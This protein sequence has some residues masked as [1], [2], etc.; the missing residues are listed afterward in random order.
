MRLKMCEKQNCKLNKE[1]MMIMYNEFLNSSQII[2]KNKIGKKDR[3]GTKFK[4][5]D[6]EFYVSLCPVPKE[7][8][9][10][11][12]NICINAISENSLPLLE[13]DYYFITMDTKY[14][15]YGIYKKK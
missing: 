10:F 3:F 11:G 7:F 12:I 14:A 8:K 1:R 4:E 6:K 2:S 5:G 9:K 13:K 15:K